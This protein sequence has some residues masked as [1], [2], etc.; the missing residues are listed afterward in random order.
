MKFKVN[1]TRIVFFLIFDQ[2][3]RLLLL[4][5]FNSNIFFNNKYILILNFLINKRL[6]STKLI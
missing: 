5:L 6:I 4:L 3:F 1:T 2:R